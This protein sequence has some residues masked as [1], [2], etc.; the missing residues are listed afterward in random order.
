MT[1]RAAPFLASANRPRVPWVLLRTT[2]SAFVKDVHIRTLSFRAIF[3]ALRVAFLQCF[4]TAIQ[5]WEVVVGLGV[6]VARSEAHDIV[7]HLR[8]STARVEVTG[9]K[10]VVVVVVVDSKSGASGESEGEEEK[11]GGCGKLHDYLL[12]MV[13]L[14][15]DGFVKSQLKGLYVSIG[16]GAVVAVI[17]GTVCLI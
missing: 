3:R 2:A 5:A 13:V 1:S 15:I 7:I 12:G 6:R 4:M 17:D 10:A 9:L 14:R 8:S 11:G 16:R